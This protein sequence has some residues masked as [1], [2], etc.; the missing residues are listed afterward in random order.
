M[1]TRRVDG[2]TD[3]DVVPLRLAIRSM[4]DSGYKN[5]AYA[6]AELVD[7]SVQ[8]GATC[9][10]IL[11]KEVE[12]LVR[13]RK[14]TRVKQIAVVDDGG[15]MTK[16]VLRRALQFGVGERT[17][18]RSGIGRFGMGLPNSS[19]SQAR[20]VDVWSWSSGGASTA[21]YS[22]L[23]LDEIDRGDLKHV[24]E[25]VAKP[26]PEEWARISDTIRTSRSGTIVVWS[27]LDKCDWR[28][29]HAIFKNSEF[30]IGRIYR[31]FLQNKRVRI[32]MASFYEGARETNFSEDAK[33]NDPIYLSKVTSCAAP[34]DTEA[35]FEEYG[36]PHKIPVKQGG[37]KYEVTVRFSIAKKAARMERNAGAE[38]W[39]KHAANNIG[40]SVMRADRELELQTGWC[41]GYDPRE[42]WWGV[43]VDFPP[44]LDEVFGVPNNKQEARALAEYAVI[45]LDQIAERE[46]FRSE[47]ALVEA[48]TEDED[49]RMV[50]VRVKQTIESNL[51][52]IRQTLKAQAERSKGSRRHADPDSAEVRGTKATQLRQKDGHVGVSDA[53]E[54]L[55]AEEK[56]QRIAKSLSDQGL[57]Q[58]EA[59]ERAKAVVYDGRKFD[60]FETELDGPELFTVRA[61]AGAILIGL[62]TAHPGYDHLVALLKRSEETKDLAELQTR[63]DQAYEGLK[64]LLE[65][66]ARYEDELP[67]GRKKEQAQEARADW[68]RVARDF[69]RD[70]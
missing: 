45:K 40:V 2:P 29:A 41:I 47:Q 53:E 54:S 21:M 1:A 49:P 18:D 56:E 48:W 33:P 63:L 16:D 13:Q 25:P 69:F 61:K 26:V 8:A 31:R 55:S 24:P 44:V 67:D 43:E 50:L 22:Y 35:M 9:V 11:C 23:D 28:T 5:A 46:G 3:F 64:L 17:E 19:I 70:E 14:R 10:E 15:G 66:W 58:A 57:D 38:P 12:E 68:G 39:G 27:Q 37:K 32:R 52:V 4:R 36:S 34:W 51:G 30:T 59:S 62:N 42:R 7:N 65:A 6:I 20:R 60:F